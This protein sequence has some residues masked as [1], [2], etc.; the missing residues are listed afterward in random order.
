MSCHCCCVPTHLDPDLFDGRSF[1]APKPSSAARLRNLFRT[2]PGAESGSAPCA[3][4]LPVGRENKNDQR[5]V[6]ARG[7]KRFEIEKEAPA[8]PIWERLSPR[9]VSFLA[10][11]PGHFTL[12]GTNCYI[13]GTGKRRILID[14]GDKPNKSLPDFGWLKVLP[15]LKKCMAEIGCEGFSHILVTHLHGD[16]YGG[17]ELLLK[18]FPGPTKVGLIPLSESGSMLTLWNQLHRR[19]IAPIIRRGKSPWNPDTMVFSWGRVREKDLEPWP[20]EDLS[21]DPAGRTKLEL[22]IDGCICFRILENF[23]NGWRDGPNRLALQ[24]N[25]VITTEGATLRVLHTPGHAETHASFLLEE[26]NSIFSG[27]N[28]LGYG[29]TIMTNLRE[30]MDS[31]R[32]MVSLRPVKLYPGHGPHIED[33]TGLL[34]R[35][36]EHR[37]DRENQVVDFLT[38]RAPLEMEELTDALYLDTPAARK[39][40]AREN[41][42]RIL[43][44]LLQEEKADCQL[45]GQHLSRDAF[46]GVNQVKK[47]PPGARWS[48]KST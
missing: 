36:I 35:Y 26:E 20:D 39:V 31:L 3:S 41:I 42:T 1:F 37:Q 5:M 22:H 23:Y 16:H 11:N 28:V 47:L 18:T 44:K 12:N 15:D 38:Q 9:V 29:T 6:V 45:D 19:G 24:D 34:T 10:G 7:M 13:I 48:I 17:V 4:S 40:L 30:Y 25:D 43:V 2:L 46:S 21:W 14:T 27:D 8:Q 33:G 32:R